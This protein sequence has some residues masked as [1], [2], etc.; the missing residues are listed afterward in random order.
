MGEIAIELTEML[1]HVCC[2]FLSFFFNCN[3]KRMM[4][5]EFG[6]EDKKLNT[7]HVKTIRDQTAV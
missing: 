6:L 7:F 3:A 5:D 2:L 4:L 1:C